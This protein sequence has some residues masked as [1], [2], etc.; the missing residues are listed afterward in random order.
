MRGAGKQ[1]SLDGGLPSGGVLFWN[2]VTDDSNGSTYT[3]LQQLE[4]ERG[5]T[6]TN[7]SGCAASASDDVAVL[8]RT[9]S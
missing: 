7:A 2:W 3:I 6:V 4:M 5:Y 1:S 8:S 9:S